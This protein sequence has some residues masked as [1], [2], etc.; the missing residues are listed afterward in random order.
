M[1]EENVER[2]RRG[3]EAFAQGGPEAVVDFLDPEIELWLPS[4]LIQS[5]G[6]YRGRAAVLAWMKEFADAWDEIE[7]KAEEFTDA[8]DAVVI[9]V[10]YDGRGKG[11][12]VRTQGRFWYV[13]K[14]R[15]ARL[16]RWEL[17]PERRQALEAAGL[18]E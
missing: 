3:F 11:S 6:T 1:S 17:Y 18:S 12:G 2:A 8:G 9:T 14:E 5:G 13:F 15:D 4:G 16:K 7:Y 10:L